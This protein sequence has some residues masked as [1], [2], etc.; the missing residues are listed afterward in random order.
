MPLLKAILGAT[1]LPAESLPPK[2]P[3]LRTP[4]EL[5]LTATWMPLVMAM[6][7]PSLATV[8]EACPATPSRT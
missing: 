6:T 2:D 4:T 7:D 1:M 5:L 3:I 8:R